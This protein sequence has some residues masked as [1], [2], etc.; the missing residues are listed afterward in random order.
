MKRYFLLMLLALSLLPERAAAQ[1][2]FEGV[3]VS[4]RAGALINHPTSGRLLLE[5]AEQELRSQSVLLSAGFDVAGALGIWLRFGGLRLRS[6]VEGGYQRGEIE[7]RTRLDA[8]PSDEG[9]G[10]QDGVLFL[11]NNY[12]NFLGRGSYHQPWAGFGLGVA[13]QRQRF[14]WRGRQYKEAFKTDFAASLA[15]GYDYRLTDQ[16]GVGVSY[17]YVHIFGSVFDRYTESRQSQMRLGISYG[18]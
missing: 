14:Y 4:M 12:F 15:L 2:W 5:D 1:D 17:R 13:L 6:E 9:R 10:F 16:F 7:A 3:Y 8:S 11:W 18:Y